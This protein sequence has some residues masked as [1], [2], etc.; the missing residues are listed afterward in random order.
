MKRFLQDESGE[1]VLATVAIISLLGIGI[2]KG[3]DAIT[4]VHDTCTITTQTEV[5]GGTLTRVKQV[6]CPKEDEKAAPIDNV[7]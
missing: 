1:V 2:A 4:P 3:V 7:S 6:E 5:E